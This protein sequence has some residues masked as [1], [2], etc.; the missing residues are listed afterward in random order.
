MWESDLGAGRRTPARSTD[1]ILSPLWLL[2]RD[3]GSVHR[4]V[5]L[6]LEE[7]G[8]SFGIRNLPPNAEH[9]PPARPGLVPLLRWGWQ[10]SPAV[11]PRVVEIV[12]VI[13]NGDGSGEDTCWLRGG[14]Q[15]CGV[16]GSVQS[17]CRPRASETR[18]NRM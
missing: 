9:C 6:S 14:G 3:C 8:T 15:G 11:L 17:A 7:G 18:S 10:C 2:G 16:K 1:R 5:Y 4:L 12:T 13:L